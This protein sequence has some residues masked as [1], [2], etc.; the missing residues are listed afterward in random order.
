MRL[1]DIWKSHEGGCESGRLMGCETQENKG[2]K[3]KIKLYGRNYIEKW[4]LVL[5]NVAKVSGESIST[6]K[7]EAACS[8]ETLEIFYQATQLYTQKSEIFKNDTI[9]KI[10]VRITQ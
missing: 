1:S 4:S 6:L 10:I 7:T 9:T 5:Q 2:T 8:S 3:A